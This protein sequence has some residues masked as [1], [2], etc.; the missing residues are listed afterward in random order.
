MSFYHDFRRSAPT[1]KII[2]LCRAEACQAVGSEELAAYA[3][4]ALSMKSG[5]T[6]SEG[7]V[8]IEAVY[9][10]GNCALGP[11]RTR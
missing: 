9:C 4:K 5:D 2:K 3:E 11:R 6:P 7:G 8:A 10:L 1:G